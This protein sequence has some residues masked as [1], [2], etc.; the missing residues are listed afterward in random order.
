MT[1]TKWVLVVAVVELVVV[2]VVDEEETDNDD[3]FYINDVYDYDDEKRTTKMFNF[4]CCALSI[5][6]KYSHEFHF[7]TLSLTGFL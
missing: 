5:Y 4:L 1:N 7:I 2:V 3:D 6:F